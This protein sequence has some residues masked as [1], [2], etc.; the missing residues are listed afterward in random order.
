MPRA[1]ASLDTAL[2]HKQLLRRQ[3]K[4]FL[5]YPVPENMPIIGI[6]VSDLHD[7]D[8]VRE[9]LKGISAL[10]VPFVIFA[11]KKESLVPFDFYDQ[12]AVIFSDSKTPEN[13]A[14][15]DAMICFSK[16]TVKKCFRSKIGPIALEGTGA[17][18]YHPNRETGNSFVFAKKD[19]WLVYAALVRVMETFRFPFD[20]KCIIRN[21]SNF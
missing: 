9:L 6:D 4:N 1:S 17:E 5:H 3:L 21:S 18:N 7:Y 14:G 15:C 8:L 20:W 13:F 2:D 11:E 19:A 12:A 10:G 16:E